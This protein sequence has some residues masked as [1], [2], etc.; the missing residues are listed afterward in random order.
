MLQHSI[1]KDEIME[2]AHTFVEGLSPNQEADKEHVAN[3][4]SLYRSG[5]VYNVDFDGYT[6]SGTAEA[7]GTIYSV[8][9]L[10]Q[11]LS[12]SYCDC[13][14]ATQCEHMLA[15]LLSA[16]A[17]FGKVGDVLTLFKKKNKPALPPIRTARQVLQ[18]TLFEE[19]DYGSWLTYFEKEYTSYKAEQT[20][21]SYKQMY[22]L[23]NIFSEFYTRIERKAPRVVTVHE[24]FK[25]H[26]A[27]F[28]F[29]KLLQEIEEFEEKGGYSYHQP[30]QIVR[31]FVD[32]IDGLI[33]DLRTESIPAKLKP[34]LQEIARAI[35]SI[36]FATTS[37][38]PE[39]FFL[40][41]YAWSELLFEE[42]FIKEEK[43]RIDE[44]MQPVLKALAYTH[45]LFLQKQDDD[46]IDMLSN[47]TPKLVHLYFHWIED[48]LHS[49]Q[50]DRAKRWISFTYNQVK[51]TM[52]ETDEPY[53]IREIVHMFVSTYET[54]ATQTNE[55][56][57]YE[58]I[59]QE[60]L[61]YSF[62]DYEQYILAK[63]QYH[64]WAELHLFY[65]FDAIE[66]LKEPL[67]EVEKAAPEA[68]LPLYHIAV[69]NTIEEKNRKSY[70]R[71]VRY[72]KKLRTLYKKL[73]RTDEWQTY[74][75][76]IASSHSRLRA[77]QEEMRKGKLIDD[78]T[79]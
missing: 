61:P 21:L 6:L 16:A 60:L 9:I 14:S 28:S 4:L 19:T 51:E 12:D 67:K 58:M 54:Y 18:T 11:K 13:F 23:M 25:L 47:Q 55:Q 62:D 66:Y 71:A 70:R 15:V 5:L 68:A 73:K 74:I 57:G 43:E 38:I 72:L 41:H 39:R 40:Y 46:A 22:F 2:L 20:K 26:A 33:R 31:L 3:A 77:L 32:K 29:E 7:D 17:S 78:N 34:A 75:G 50:W 69:V 10:I 27:L 64:T 42:T 59:L 1:T 49:M 63:Q 24:L 76:M 48:L 35:H 8:N 52:K 30:V 44:K 45:L 37:Y 56:A 36:F 79:N 65:G 53:F